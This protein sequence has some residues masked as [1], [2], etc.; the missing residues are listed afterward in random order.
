MKNNKT[1]LTSN[2]EDYLEAIYVLSERDGK[3]RVKGI[4]DKLG[5][6]KPSVNN[7]VN[8]LLRKGLVRHEKYGNIMLTAPGVKLSQNIKR[9]HDMLVRFLSEILGVERDTAV[10]DACRVEH[11]ISA[12]TS[13]RLSKFMEFADTFS[14][15]KK[16]VWL[17]SFRVFLEHG[18]R[19]YKPAAGKMKEKEK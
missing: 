15:G 2:M 11:V 16:P 10:Q 19:P 4:S 5:V 17:E 12:V 8:V 1:E 13:E 6:K 18:K 14:S 7:A 3:A 9:R